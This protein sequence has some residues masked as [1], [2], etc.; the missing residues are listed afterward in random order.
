MPSK[1]IR[2]EDI[3]S[4][5]E[6]L[7]SEGFEVSKNKESEDFWDHFSIKATLKS[8]NGK[9]KF[10]GTHSSECKD[11]VILRS[12]DKTLLEGFSSN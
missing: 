10:L 8:E 7:I 4:V 1:V 12:K 9:I 5:L 6:N 3:K 2:T 11:T